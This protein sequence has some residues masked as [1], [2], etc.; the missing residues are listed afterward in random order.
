M[1]IIPTLILFLY[2]ILICVFGN[3]SD[4]LIRVIDENQLVALEALLVQE[5]V[6]PNVLSSKNAH[7]L[8]F[9]S[10]KQSTIALRLLLTH[11]ANA[12]FQEGDGWTA[13][14]FACVQ[15]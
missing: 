13:L 9:A 1:T 11:G 12:N 7:P 3:M 8:I 4:D 14:M 15:V 5:H 2:C 6:D 10:V